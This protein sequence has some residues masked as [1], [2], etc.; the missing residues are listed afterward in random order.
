MPA[1]E[2]TYSDKTYLSIVGGN[3]SQKVNEGTPGAVRREY[4]LKNGTKGIKYEIIHQGWHGMIRS[5]YAKE[6]EF[7]EV[8]NVVFDDA[9]I[10]IPT[11]SRY[12]SDFAKKIMSADLDQEVFIAPFD[13]ETD[14][15]KR[16]TGV[17]VIQN[18]IKLKNFYW[19]EEAKK[20]IKMF[21]VPEGDT[22]T[23]NSDDWRVYFIQ[24]KRFLLSQL[25]TL[26]FSNK[27]PE[28]QPEP[29][30][31]IPVIQLDKEDGEVKIEDVPF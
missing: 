27:T 11:N 22:R 12:F 21:P 8:L 25:S 2:K 14:E 17:S 5:I 16:M 20:P 9:V 29:I 31:D 30:D 7:G 6:G 28:E 24:V 4:E 13:F 26:T 23:Y 19:D 1:I 10:S 15:G 3:L 18:G